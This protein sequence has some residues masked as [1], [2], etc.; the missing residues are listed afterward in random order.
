MVK[1]ECLRC[2]YIAKQKSNLVNHLKRKNICEPKISNISIENVKKFYGF[3]LNPNESKMNPNESK[4]LFEINEKM[5]PNESK[6]NPNLLNFESKMDSNLSKKKYICD[7]C[8]K[9]Y[10]TNSN[11]HKHLKNCKIK[12]DNIEDI[13]KKE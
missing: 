4:I 6:M 9:C 2:G 13:K 7:F 5:N 8:N 10:S 11:L 3:E 12:I 1:Y